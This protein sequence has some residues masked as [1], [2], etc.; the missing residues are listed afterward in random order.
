M[1]SFRTKDQTRSGEKISR[2]DLLKAGGA[3]AVV[4]ANAQT[5][6]AEGTKEKRLA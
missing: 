2:R 1:E 4:L 5:A 3:G 6:S